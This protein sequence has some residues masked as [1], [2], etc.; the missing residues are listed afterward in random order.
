MKEYINSIVPD[1]STV[2]N[3]LDAIEARLAADPSIS[4]KQRREWMGHFGWTTNVVAKA[5][6][7]DRATV[8]I[9]QMNES[10]DKV[11]RYISRQ[12]I[13]NSAKVMLR[14]YRRR[15]IRHAKELG[16]SPITFALEGE[17]QPARD[18]VKGVPAALSII[19]MA[20]ERNLHM[21]EYSDTALDEWG[22]EQM[23]K[24]S[25]Y[26][27]VIS[28]KSAFRGAIR[29][30]GLQALFRHLS[31]SIAATYR[32]GARELPQWLRCQIAIMI[33]NMRAEARMDGSRFPITAARGLVLRFREL[34]GYA[35]RLGIAINRLEELLAETLIRDYILFLHNE[36]HWKRA[37]ILSS[38]NRICNALRFHP[39]LANYDYTW[40]KSCILELPEDDDTNI[41]P[42]A[43]GTEIVLDDLAEIPN[44]ICAKRKRLK[45]KNTRVQAWLVL[46]EFVI[47]FLVTHPWPTQCLRMCR[48]HHPRRNV[49]RGPIP[50]DR[51]PFALF[52]GAKP[53]SLENRGLSLWQFDF[54]PEHMR[55]GRYA[56]G[57]LVRPLISKL[58]LYL[59]YRKKLLEGK[60]DPGTLLVNFAGQPFRCE[61]FAKLV[62]DTCAEYCGVRVPPSAFRRK[63]LFDWLTEYPGDVENLAAILWINP[64]SVSVEFERRSPNSALTLNPHQRQWV[65]RC[66][67]YWG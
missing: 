51:A 12:P 16:W 4:E 27:F 2:N 26:R 5:L 42:A 45:A 58:K 30:A 19:L 56:R 47:F 18:A 67:S 1:Q 24:G 37:S 32:I 7:V 25:T 60:P 22:K 38:V 34:F 41:D 49:F 31:T 44:K 35:N 66:R 28:R 53:E 36:K 65:R 57:P 15:M 21:S 40:I 43:D 55:L 29:S 10:E 46:K 54:S 20:I 3:L 6:N 48:I 52:V 8:T 64:Q 13:S 33:W 14:C 11:R 59:K 63:F 23:R 39:T 61:E 9:Q 62:T 17:W 50:Q